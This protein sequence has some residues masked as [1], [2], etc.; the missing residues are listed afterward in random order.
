MSLLN[1]EIP[2]VDLRAAVDGI[3]RRWWIVVL[4]IL[5]AIGV[6]FAQ[7]SGLRTEPAGS[8]NVERTYEAL[9][10][11]DALDIVKVDPAA[12]V[13]V[14]SFDNQLAILRTQETLDELR[15]TAS[16]DALIEITRSEPK[17][18][19][20]E[21]IDDLNNKVSFLSTG[22]PAYTYRC[23]GSDAASCNSLIDAYVA[24]T[25]EL[26][27]ESVLGGLAHGVSLVDDL[28]SKA[29]ARLTD[30]TLT[31]EQLTPQRVELA[32]LLTKRDALE[33][34]TSSVTGGMVLVTQGSWTE[35]KTT[36]SV[37]A[38]TYGFGL[39]VGLIV[40]LLLALQLAAFDKTIRRAW[41][42]HRVSDELTILGSPFGADTAGQKTALAAA[43]EHARSTGAT[44][45]LLVTHD[46]AMYDFAHD[47]LQL[48]PQI[49]G[50]VITSVADASVNELAGGQSRGVIIL[51]K[52]GQTTRRQLAETLGAVTSG[53]N[54]VLGVALVR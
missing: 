4:S 17:F 32:S 23:V 31:S 47:I 27:K 46:P 39:V 36:A 19:I 28:I 13:P 53:G 20:V 44:S 29:Q 7:D 35:G 38:S 15:Q 51:V 18:T 22:T 30:G 10:E 9:V 37:S 26:R 45:A 24:K 16:S 1:S 8:V 43:L 5:I 34:V 52:S 2:S 6:V 3:A 14:P 12:I 42:V 25:V 54:R 41:Q 33:N 40:G 11:T 48:V 21:T 50:T 49:P